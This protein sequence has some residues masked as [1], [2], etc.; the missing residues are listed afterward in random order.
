MPYA[1]TDW[2]GWMAYMEEDGMKTDEAFS[3]ID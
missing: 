2:P 1:L 3:I